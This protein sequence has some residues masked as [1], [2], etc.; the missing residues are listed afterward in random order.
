MI[1]SFKTAG[2]ASENIVSAK[3][4]KSENIELQTAS[5]KA[6]ELLKRDPT[7]VNKSYKTTR[8]IR[9]TFTVVTYGVRIIA[10]D[11]ENKKAIKLKI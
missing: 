5:V 10:V 3:R 4:L 1:I 2:H 11:V 7:W 8:V 9:K 6:R